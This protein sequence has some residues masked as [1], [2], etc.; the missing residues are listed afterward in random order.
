MFKSEFLQDFLQ[1]FIILKCDFLGF[2][3]RNIGF[4]EIEILFNSKIQRKLVENDRDNE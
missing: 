1:F 4:Y 3:L 2:S